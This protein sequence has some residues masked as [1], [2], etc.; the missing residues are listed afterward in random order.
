MA[1]AAIP[2]IATAISTAVAVAGQV[3]QAKAQSS[4]ANYNQEVAQRNAKIAIIQGNQDAEAQKRKNILTLGAMRA[5]YGAAGVTAEGSPL[6]VLENSATNMELDRQTI[7]SRAR[8]RAM[9]YGDDAALSGMSG[10]AAR[11]GAYYGATGIL[12]S[13]AAQGYGQYQD[14]SSS[15]AGAST[16]Y[17]ST[18]GTV[19]SYSGQFGHV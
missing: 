2:L 16:P 11:Q 6:D 1:V 14:Y 4:A 15:T 5:S 13:G 10:D 7:L 8:L 17:Y 19:N 3:Q 12:L 18:P 9:G